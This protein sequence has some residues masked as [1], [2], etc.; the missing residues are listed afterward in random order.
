MQ[1]TINDLLKNAWGEIEII[2][3]LD[4]RWPTNLLQ[5]NSKVI[6]IFHGQAEKNLGMR[7]SINRG[8]LIANGQYIMKVDEHCT[9]DKGYDIKLI[10]DCDENWVVAPRKFDLDAEAWKPMGEAVDNVAFAYPSL[11]Y[12][13]WRSWHHQR[14][15]ILIDDCLGFQGSCYFM[16]R[17]HWDW[18]GGLDDKAYGS[19]H[20]E[21]Q[22]ICLKTW[23]GGGRVVTNKKTWYGHW[24]RNRKDYSF[25]PRQRRE[26]YDKSISKRVED[27]WLNDRWSNKIHNFEWL[28]EKF[29]PVPY[30]PGDWRERI[31]ID[32]EKYWS[33]DSSKQPTERVDVGALEVNEKP[34]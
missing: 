10:A 6:T 32:A 31:K 27:Y 11:N 29:W 25:S 21:P 16:S 14:K 7:M 19:F 15:D 34:S 9:F 24:H 33:K 4:G 3:V 5:N 28:I 8:V 1:E 13:K 30:W 2:V 17:K 18:L 20:Y 22:E 23:L 12:V 26:F